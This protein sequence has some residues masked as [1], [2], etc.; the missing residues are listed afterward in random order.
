[1]AACILWNIHQEVTLGKEDYG[2]GADGKLPPIPVE[3]LVRNNPL[4][5]ENSDELVKRGR[6]TISSAE[7]R[8]AEI[9]RSKIAKA[10][11]ADWVRGYDSGNHGSYASDSEYDSS[12]SNE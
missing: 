7:K 5:R 2:Q 9:M 11:W 1:M 6:T 4:S 10:M 12:S 8:E 3:D